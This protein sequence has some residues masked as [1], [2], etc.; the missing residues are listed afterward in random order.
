MKSGYQVITSWDEIH[1][2]QHTRESWEIQN[3]LRSKHKTDPLKF[4]KK[5]KKETKNV[6]LIEK[7]I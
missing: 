5:R 3:K 1:T 7:Y 2:R 4:K 6:P